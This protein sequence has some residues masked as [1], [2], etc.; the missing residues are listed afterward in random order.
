MKGR[1]TE[2][3]KLAYGGVANVAETLQIRAEVDSRWNGRMRP[4]LQTP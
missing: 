3:P 4:Y 1:V 2:K